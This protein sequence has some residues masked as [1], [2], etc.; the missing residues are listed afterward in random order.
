MIPGPPEPLPP[1]WPLARM[2]FTAAVAPY[3]WH[4][5]VAGKGPDVALIHGAGASAHS[6]RH[7]LPVLAEDH[8]VIA[9]DL[10]GHGKTRARGMR[11]GL[12]PMAADLAALFEGI[13]AKPRLL[14]GHSAGGALA[15]SLAG[16]LKPEGIVVLNGAL[17]N[18]RGPAGFLFPAIAKMLSINPFAAPLLARSATNPGAVERVIGAT[19]AR[20]DAEGLENYRHLIADRAHVAG[21]LAMMASWSLN[22]LTRDLPHIDTPVLFLHGSEDQAVSPDV[23]RRAA[24][25]MPNA[26]IEVIP[27]VGHLLQEEAPAVVA[28][29]IRAFEASLTE[30]A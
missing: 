29:R 1:G 22:G 26:E 24:A 3:R 27:G 2:S 13:E 4:L 21:T 15:L 20:I 14:V 6:W 8:R 7:L 16:R 17:E 28:E 5:A 10:P 30:P 12:E 25:M 11:S 9:P 18:F 19:G 23:S